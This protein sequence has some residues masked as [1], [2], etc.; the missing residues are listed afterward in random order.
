[1]S[2]AFLITL[3]RLAFMT[4]LVISRMIDSKRLESTANSTGS[5]SATLCASDRAGPPSAIDPAYPCY[6]FVFRG[7][8]HHSYCDHKSHGWIRR[9][10][11]GL[12][13]PASRL[14]HAVA[15]GPIEGIERVEIGA[16]PA[17]N[18]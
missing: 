8:Y 18:I 4:V 11:P 6:V 17:G 5:K 3:E 10:V 16:A 13:T 7:K 1:M 9:G 12:A 15:L 2:R 14:L